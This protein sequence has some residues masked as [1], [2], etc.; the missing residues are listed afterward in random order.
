MDMLIIAILFLSGTPLIFFPYKEYHLLEYNLVMLN[1]ALNN[2]P[3][4]QVA[5]YECSHIIKQKLKM[6]INYIFIVRP[7]HG[8]I[9]NEFLKNELYRNV[10]N[11]YKSLR[12]RYFKL[13]SL[14][15]STILILTLYSLFK[16]L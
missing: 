5:K 6:E 7:S 15:I 13:T 8:K 14:L 9:R 3:D 11:K 16:Q 12:S 10:A 1:K 2:L 4:E